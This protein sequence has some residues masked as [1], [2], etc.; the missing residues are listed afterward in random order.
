MLFEAPDAYYRFVLTKGDTS[1]FRCRMYG[2]TFSV[3]GK[4]LKQE[5]ITR[6]NKTILLSLT[7]KMPIRRIAKVTDINATT[8]YGKIDFI[9]GQFLAFAASRE[10]A[11]NTMEIDRL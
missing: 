8:L 4:A 2:K 6:Q 10:K 7:D 5:R 9:H 3:G 1:G 11:V